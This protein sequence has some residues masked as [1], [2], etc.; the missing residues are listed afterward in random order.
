MCILWDSG[1]EIG[2][3]V[4]SDENI[5]KQLHVQISWDDITLNLNKVGHL[6]KLFV[7]WHKN[8]A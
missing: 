1:N 3:N 4:T 5:K 7:K 2:D 6:E 8:S